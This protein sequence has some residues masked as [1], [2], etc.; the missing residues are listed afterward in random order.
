MDFDQISKIYLP[1][2]ST[3]EIKRFF[4][5]QDREFSLRFDQSLQQYRNNPVNLQM[6]VQD[7]K[8]V[9]LSTL[10]SFVGCSDCATLTYK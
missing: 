5:E 9:M 7:E 4:M 3:V 1:Q 6:F 10:D 2:R 8:S